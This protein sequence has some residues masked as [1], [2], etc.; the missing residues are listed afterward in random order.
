MQISTHGN[1]PL[2]PNTDIRHL[3]RA[4]SDNRIATIKTRHLCLYHQPSGSIY[5]G[6]SSDIPLTFKKKNPTMM[7]RMNVRAPSSGDD[8]FS[9]SN[10]WVGVTSEAGTASE[11]K[12]RA[13]YRWSHATSVSPYT[14]DQ[15]C[16]SGEPL[17]QGRTKP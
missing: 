9:F 15:G 17:R 6:L 3:G 10:F 16:T 11:T 12:V 2:L 13:N 8:R 7:F 5:P 4:R 1:L 14:P